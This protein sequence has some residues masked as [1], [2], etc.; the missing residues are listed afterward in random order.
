MLNFSF[1]KLKFFRAVLAISFAF[2]LIIGSGVNASSATTRFVMPANHKAHE[3]IPIEKQPIYENLITQ[4]EDSEKSL[5]LEATSAAPSATETFVDFYTHLTSV[6]DHLIPYYTDPSIYKT[7]G[8]FWSSKDKENFKK[9]GEILQD[10]SL[11]LDTTN[12]T[13]SIRPQLAAHRAIQLKEIFDYIFKHATEPISLEASDHAIGEIQSDPKSGVVEFPQSP[14]VL[15]S[16]RSPKSAPESTSKTGEKEGL[17]LFTTETVDF[18]PGLYDLIKQDI[19]TTSDVRESRFYTPGFYKLISETPGHLIAPKWYLNL[20]AN[21]RSVADIAF[22]ENTLIQILLAAAFT[23]I[24]L[25]FTALIAV[26]FFKTY[27]RKLDSDSDEY[28]SKLWVSLQDREAWTRLFLA[29]IFVTA[30]SITLAQGII[31]YANIT[32]SPLLILTEVFNFIYYLGLSFTSFILFEL[33]G[34]I[35]SDLI[36]SVSPNRSSADLKWISGSI[37]PASRL[38]GIAFS[39]YYIYQ[40]L[41]SFGLPPSTILA[42]SA[43]PGLAIGLGAS[44]MLSNLIAGLVIQTD[45]PIRVG[46]FV[47]IGGTNGFVSQVGLR[48]IKLETISSLITL[49]NAKADESNI[50][51][52]MLNEKDSN[53]N[54]CRVYLINLSSSQQLIHSHE[55]IYKIADELKALLSSEP[56]I[57]RYVL[58]AKP[59]VI[60]AP[61]KF[62][63]KIFTTA[64]N[65]VEHDA[66]VTNY[67]NLFAALEVK[68]PGREPGPEKILM[69]QPSS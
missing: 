41:I 45:R 58:I 4:Q 38:V 55:N 8:A 35:F 36:V 69:L 68:Y 1:K 14:L 5:I 65:W 29:I 17:Y 34:R 61:A 50:N 42:F 59:A 53:G 6:Y 51:N 26:P 40:L 31:E 56:L 21:I 20:P 25:I 47:D 10:A 15:S 39:T 67:N 52:Y 54:T 24:Y 32:G 22:G 19:P 2:T 37:M 43:V 3:Y 16:R 60:D 23:L 12:I 11:A 27:R 44:K 57:K 13:E 66:I 46:D 62:V 64:T 33:I 28:T 49:P 63:C 18:I 7:G 48:S 30:T 9:Y